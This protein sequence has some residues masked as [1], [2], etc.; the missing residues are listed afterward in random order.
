MSF[1][2]TLVCEKCGRRAPYFRST[3]P[4]LPE[5]VETLSQSHCDAPGCDTSDRHIERW[6]DADGIERD[7]LTGQSEAMQHGN[8]GVDTK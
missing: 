8:S 1:C 5:W 3:D 2:L 4:G 6:L 7:P